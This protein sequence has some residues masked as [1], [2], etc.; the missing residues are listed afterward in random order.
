MMSPRRRGWRSVVLVSFLVGSIAVAGLAGSGCRPELAAGSGE[1]DL[2]PAEAGGAA[3]SGGGTSE[4]T[5]ETEP[6]PETLVACP[7]CGLETSQESVLHRPIAVS[8]DNLDVARPQSGLNDACLVYEVLAEGG[9]TRFLAFYLHTNSAAIGPVRS[10]RPYFLD[11]S[12]PLGAIL[13]HVGGSR[14]A[15]ADIQALKPSAMNVDQM[16][17]DSAFWRSDARKAPHN[18]YT[19][20]S[21]IRAASQALG[22]EPARL[23]AETP[24]SFSFCAVGTEPNLPSAQSASRFSLLYAGGIGGYTVTYDYD[25]ES[26]QWMR[27]IGGQAHVDAATGRQL[28]AT[29]VIVQYVSSW[30]VP[31]DEEGRLELALTG[32]G[33]AK[34]FTLGKV[35]DASWTKSGRKST[36]DF[37]DA[38]GDPLTLPPGPV[39][40]LI[41]PPGSQLTIQ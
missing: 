25:A 32:S 9:I 30:V 8:I 39:W 16:A 40:I 3:P 33:K 7:L 5:P 24:A 6:E 35:S 17:K 28:R 2:A 22:Y 37:T 10:I 13:A 41:V 12:M 38:L 20:T 18:V 1:G 21:L 15:L 36:I 34:V 23:S 11:L 31:G 27:Y 19:G 26:R 14:Q 29:T 4:T